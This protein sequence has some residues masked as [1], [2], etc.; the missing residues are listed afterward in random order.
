LKVGTYW[1]GNRQLGL[2]S[3][4]ATTLFLDEATGMPTALV[5]SGYLTGIRTAAADAV[6][7]KHLARA[8]AATLGVVGAGHQAWFDVLAICEVRPI[9]RLLVW[10]RDPDRAEA[11]AARARTELG[12][13]GESV[14]LE[15]TVRAADI[16]LTA[17]AAA[18]PLVL[19]PWVRP[20]THISAMGADSGGKQE[21]DV[22]LVAAGV[23]FA[24]V[25]RQALTIGEF[26]TAARKGMIMDRDIQTL[27]SVIAGEAR[28]PDADAI[29]IFDSSGTAVQDLAIASLAIRRSF[30]LGLGRDVALS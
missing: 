27:G 6:A 10:N 7:V 17:T 16:L 2:P 4:G 29:T 15:A 19:R 20:G 8:D 13:D 30:E 3:H 18:E 5:S 12:L 22:A 25:I 23:L 26:Q 28:R 1:P 24:D 9:R 21:L 11:F 14:P